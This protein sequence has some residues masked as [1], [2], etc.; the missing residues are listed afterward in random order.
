MKFAKFKALKMGLRPGCGALSF[1]LLL[2]LSGCGGAGGGTSAS[3]GSTSTSASTLTTSTSLSAIAQLGKKIFFDPSLSA[4]GQVACA[5]CHDPA[6][7]YGPANTLSVQ[8]GGPTLTATG[9][10][11]APQ[12]TYAYRNPIFSIG[13]D[14]STQ[15]NIN[16]AQVAASSSSTTI[17]QKVAGGSASS[18]AM[19]PQ[20]GLF[21]DGRVDT[22]QAQ[23]DGPLFNPAEMANTNVNDLVTKLAKSSYADDFKQIFGSN[24]FSNPQ[25]LLSE[26]EGAIARFEFEDASFHAFNSKYDYYL[27]GKTQL[28]ASELNG[29]KLFEDPAKGNCAAC[30]LDKKTADGQPPMFTDFQYEALGVPRNSAIP[31]NADPTFYDLGLCGPVRTDLTAQTNYCGMFRTPSLRN[32]STRK[33]YFHNGIYKSL[34]DVM[35]FYMLRDITPEQFYSRD[36]NGSVLKFNDIPALYQANVDTTDAPFNRKPGDSPALSTSEIA[37]VIAFLNTLTDGFQSANAYAP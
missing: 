1:G 13:P 16:V 9:I 28:T 7:H 10:R 27:A 35:Q 5:T 21:L 18:T 32:V 11:Q 20:G 29:L 6:Q 31:A 4:S 2:S 17:P 15:E 26:A 12:I 23:A 37:D 8:F 36:S 33:V 14:T 22:L 3:T 30:H 19:V 34:N 24:V 25:M